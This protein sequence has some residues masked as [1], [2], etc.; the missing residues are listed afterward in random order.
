VWARAWARAWAC[1]CVCVWQH[2]R[3]VAAPTVAAQRATHP[4]RE[5]L[6]VCMFVCI[7]VCVCVSV[8]AQRATH[9]QRELLHASQQAVGAAALLAALEQPQQP[10]AIHA[11][12]AAE[13]ALHCQ[14]AQPG[15]PVRRWGGRGRAG[16]RVTVCVRLCARACGVLTRGRHTE[17]EVGG[18]GEGLTPPSMP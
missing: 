5:L 7:Y 3:V 8:A 6:C 1:V 16:E 14:L 2:V 17:G 4:Q 15:S 9:P 11:G 13:A 12:A 10:R 18:L